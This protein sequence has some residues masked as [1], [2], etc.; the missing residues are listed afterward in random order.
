MT[1]EDFDG[2][3]AYE[4]KWGHAKVCTG[5]QV[6]KASLGEPTVDEFICNRQVRGWLW[7]HRVGADENGGDGKG[8]GVEVGVKVEERA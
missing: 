6:F 3:P 7:C 8:K 2:H 4:S 5:V 1:K